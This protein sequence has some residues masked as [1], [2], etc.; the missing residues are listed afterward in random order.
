MKK[1]IVIALVAIVLSS[2]K[3]ELTFD[4]MN[5][6]KAAS[7]FE[8]KILPLSK[9]DSSYI[10]GEIDGKKFRIAGGQEKYIVAQSVSKFFQRYNINPPELKNAKD[11]F[12][13]YGAVYTFRPNYAKSNI[14]Q[15]NDFEIVF[16]FPAFFSDT[17]EYQKFVTQF[18]EVGKVFSVGN[19]MTSEALLRNQQSNFNLL[20]YSFSCDLEK[21]Y[22]WFELTTFGS[23]ENGTLRLTNVKN[24]KDTNN[25]IVKRELT[26]E[27]DVNLYSGLLEPPFKR[28]KK[29]KMVLV[30]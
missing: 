18:D 5:E 12:T 10:E 11:S 4:Q 20:F 15:E 9:V 7:C 16:R 21:P 13:Y 26:F 6:R 2:C 24:M 25:K 28:I 23:Q 30:I 8:D 17:I 3:E 27:F 14:S 29:G 19:M 22:R 1:L